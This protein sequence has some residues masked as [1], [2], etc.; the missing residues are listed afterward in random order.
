MD[1][2]ALTKLQSAALIVFVVVAV[3]GGSI[4]FSLWNASQPSP[5]NIRIGICADLDNTI[6]KGIWRAAILAA[7]EVNAEGGVLGRNLTIVAADD[8]GEGSQDVAVMTSALVRLIT[9]DKAD[10]IISNVL[11][12]QGF[13]PEVDICR[14]NNKIMFTTGATLDEF[15]QR[16]L[17]DYENY[18][19]FFKLFGANTTSIATGLLDDVATVAKYGGFTKVALLYQDVSTFEQTAAILESSFPSRGLEI[20]YSVSIPV[21]STDFTSY[22]AAVEASGAEI[23]VPL[24]FTRASVPFV[25]EWYDRE[26]PFVVVGVLSGC[27]DPEFWDATGGKCE[28]VSIRGPPFVAGY[29]LTD[30]SMQTREVYLERWGTPIPTAYATAAYDGV[31]CI[32]PDAIKRAGTTETQ[33][34][35]KTLETIDAATSLARHFVF[36]KAHDFMIGV[37]GS[38]S[39]PEEYLLFGVL[40]WQANKT[41]VTVVPEGLMEDSGAKYMF[42][43]WQG[44]WAINLTP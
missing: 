7:E 4:A 29:N 25:K 36:T 27:G 42:P 20:V 3:V 44:P 14:E 30:R 22:F 17:D 8:D 33:A 31:R 5:E 16:V 39:P 26:S 32:L 21:T 18:K 38:A 35:I 9:V 28:Y 41:F 43:P 24:I 37:A 6:G 10:F 1:F 2:K 40:Q 11:S 13:F 15:P 23:V 34:V 12:P 19:Y